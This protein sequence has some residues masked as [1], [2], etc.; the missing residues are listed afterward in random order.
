MTPRWK[1]NSQG[2]D[3]FILERSPSVQPYD[4][5]EVGRV[6][7]NVTSFVNTQ[8]PRRSYSYRIRAYKG[9]SFSGYSNLDS[10]TVR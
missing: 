2:E 1:D 6:G 4:F 9:T 3:G 7:T 10:A 8:V 5:R